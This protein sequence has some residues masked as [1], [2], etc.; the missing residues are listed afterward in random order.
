VSAPRLLIVEDDEAIQEMV[1]TIAR[2]HGV[3]ID[4]AADGKKAIAKLS[5]NSHLVR[6]CLPNDTHT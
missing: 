3:V 5:T 1:A 6:C 4:A 2:R